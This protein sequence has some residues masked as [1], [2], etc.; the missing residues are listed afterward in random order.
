MALCNTLRISLRVRTGRK[1]REDIADMEETSLPQQ[2]DVQGGTYD[3]IAIGGGP[4]GTT[5]A[6]YTARAHLKTLVL[7]KGLRTGALGLANKIA[8]YPG[9]P[10]ISGAE[11]LERIRQ[12]AQ[13][14]GATFIQDRAVGAD[15]AGEIKTVWTNQSFYRCKTLIIASGSM[16]RGQ[17]LPG[18]ER[19]IGQ[20]VSYC[21]TCDGAFF[22]DQRVAV[23]GNHDEAVEEALTLTRFAREVHFLPQ[24]ANVKA[25][26]R[27]V[28]ELS[29]HPKVIMHAPTQVREIVG[30]K[31]VEGVRIAEKGG[32]ELVLP[33]EGVFLY[34]QGNRPIT[35]FLQGQLPTSPAGCLEVNEVMETGI[36]GVFAVGD[37]LCTHIKQAV[38]SAAEGAIAGQAIQRYLS[39]RD[40]LR[41]DWS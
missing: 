39:G 3:V 19:L 21:A 27:L 2:D 11:L 10:E 15:L 8:N 35:D 32:A 6:M 29:H 20:G 24:T 41:P 17:V 23:V 14:F 9:L 25:S 40:S 28:E 18:E 34:M 1:E 5:A 37:V 38:I 12:Q 13:S 30:D 16:G 31:Q 7:D 22:E 36:A 33:V 26:P 4:A